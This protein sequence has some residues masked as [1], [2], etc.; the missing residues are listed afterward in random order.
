MMRMGW[1]MAIGQVDGAAIEEAAG[2]AER[3]ERRGV[4]VLGDADGRKEGGEM[5]GAT[6]VVIR[7]RRSWR[8][9]PRRP[10]GVGM[11][12]TGMS[13]RTAR[14]RV[15]GAASMS[16][17]IE[18]KSSGMRMCLSRKRMRRGDGG[19]SMLD[20]LWRADRHDVYGAN[21]A[22]STFSD[23]LSVAGASRP[24]RFANRATSTARS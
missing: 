2:G 7:T 5:A 12:P 10:D 14:P 3:D 16:V 20:T 22:W 1:Q 15:R 11:G 24:S 21:I 8:R 18:F 6:S 19:A 23:R 4:A 9:E 17:A 13:Y